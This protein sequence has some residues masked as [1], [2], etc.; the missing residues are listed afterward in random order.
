MTYI[1]VSGLTVR[2]NWPATLRGRGRRFNRAAPMQE[3][4]EFFPQRFPNKQAILRTYVSDEYTGRDPAY[5][6]TYVDS[7][8]AVTAA[9]VL[10][11]AQKYLHPDQ[12]V[13]LAVGESEV[14]LAG[15][16][17]KD[18]DVR[19]DRFGNVSKL[20]LRDPDTLTR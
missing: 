4:A 9:D 6:Q 16:H 14:L 20:P 11:V 7:L 13:V 3:L 2:S 5:W 10:R 15:G 1:A 8:K 19:F 18:P 17:D 12:L